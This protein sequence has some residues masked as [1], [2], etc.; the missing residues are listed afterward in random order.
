MNWSHKEQTKSKS[1]QLLVG[2]F[3]IFVNILLIYWE[4]QASPKYVQVFSIEIGSDSVKYKHTE[5]RPKLICSYIKK[6]KNL[7]DS[8]LM[9]KRS[10]SSLLFFLPHPGSRQFSSVQPLARDGKRK[11]CVYE[12][13]SSLHEFYEFVRWNFSSRSSKSE[14]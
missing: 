13:V 4:R 12:F 10:G 11:Y 7:M 1:Q 3:L 8:I 5:P 6:E 2:L 9:Y 14:K